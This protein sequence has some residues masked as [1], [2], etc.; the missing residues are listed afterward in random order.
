MMN[1]I[2]VTIIAMPPSGSSGNVYGITSADSDGLGGWYI[3][4]VNVVGIASPYTGWDILDNTGW[5]GSVDCSGA[6]PA[7]TCSY[8]DPQ[9]AAGGSGA[10]GLVFPWAS[11]TW[12]VYGSSGIHHDSGTMLPGDDA[13]DFVGGDSYGASVMPAYA[14]AAAAGTVV[15][16]CP[17]AHNE[18]IIVSGTSGK[19]MYFHFLPGQAKLAVG[20]VLTQG[21]QI[22]ALARGTFDDSPCGY[23]S[24]AATEYHIHFGWVPS[25]GY[26]QMGNCDLDLSSQNWV[27][28]TTTVNI[29]GHLVNG[30]EVSANPTATGPTVTPGG[31]TV[32]PSV[33]STVVGGEHIWNGIISGLIDFINSDAARVLPSH[34]SSTTLPDAVNNIWSTVLSFGWMI[35]SL[36]MIWALPALIVY[37]VLI[38]IEIVRWV[39]VAY[40]FI[41]GLLP[42]K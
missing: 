6:E 22:G 37:G 27:C 34:T 15:S 36:Q 13:V 25:G 41:I 16:N 42:M 3:S 40:R 1:A 7:W 20:T 26:L 8:F 10:T 38:V 14:Y 31:P 17:G 5:M 24:Q 9:Y 23:A 2:A 29:L 32:T 30:G 39:Y 21:E 18:G 28:G 33:G 12:A 4:L 11:G 35:Q 19:F